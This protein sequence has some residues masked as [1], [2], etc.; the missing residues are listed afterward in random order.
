M[1]F[2]ANQLKHL[3]NKNIKTEIFRKNNTC[4]FIHKILA[5]TNCFFLLW[6]I[7]FKTIKLFKILH[8]MLGNF[9][10]SWTRYPKTSATWVLPTCCLPHVTQDHPCHRS[11]VKTG[12]S[13]NRKNNK[14][15]H[16]L[17]YSHVFAYCKSASRSTINT[18]FYKP[19]Q[20]V[21]STIF[22]FSIKAL[23]HLVHTTYISIVH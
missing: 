15:G 4:I 9:S 20:E 18:V 1:H 11:K 3:Y 7:I 6:K 21:V 17:T 16:K 19:Y 23:F 22:F 13:C 14:T 5:L 2:S 12:K 8:G 10:T